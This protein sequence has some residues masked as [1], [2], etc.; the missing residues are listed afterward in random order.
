M[1]R[2][3]RR[4]VALEESAGP[5]ESP[6]WSA[7]A[8]IEDAVDKLEFYRRFHANG[9]ARYSATD[10]E[11]H[12]LGLVCAFWALP[13]GVGKHRYPS[14]VVVEWTEEDADGMQAVN[15]SGNVPLEDL[16]EEV[17]QFFVRMDPAKQP[18][19]ERFLYENRHRAKKERARLDWHRE[20]GFDK[21]TPEHLSKHLRARGEGSVAHG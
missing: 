12:S 18:E 3:R 9:S 11:I 5:Q 17:R 10:R 16:P 14:G 6:G 13:D 4:L 19:R 1:G 8:Q 7:E 21:P 20:H 15:A 2:I